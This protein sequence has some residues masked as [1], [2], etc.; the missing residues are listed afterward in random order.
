[1]IHSLKNSPAKHRAFFIPKYIKDKWQLIR[2]HIS[3]TSI[4]F[5]DNHKSYLIYQSIYWKR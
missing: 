1:L 4:S 2:K 3:G 5:M